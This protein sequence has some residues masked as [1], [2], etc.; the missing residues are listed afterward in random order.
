LILLDSKLSQWKLSC[1]HC[2]PLTLAGTLNHR[3]QHHSALHDRHPFIRTQIIFTVHL[4]ISIFLLLL[5]KAIK[6]LCFTLGRL[7]FLI[8]LPSFSSLNNSTVAEIGRKMT[9]PIGT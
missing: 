1:F 5:I 2:A 9:T 6:P 8:K 4:T 3:L 7:S